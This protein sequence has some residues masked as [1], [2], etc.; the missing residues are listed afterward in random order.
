MNEIVI[1][2]KLK[3][4]EEYLDEVYQE[5][6]KLFNSTHA[7]DEGCIQYDFHKDLEDKYSFTF[8]ETWKNIELL[9]QHMQKDHFLQFVKNS[10]NKLVNLEINR[11][12]KI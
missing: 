8:V 10:E 2:A 3:I 4:K 1:V 5:L 7:H 11:L 6:V 12:Q 9:E